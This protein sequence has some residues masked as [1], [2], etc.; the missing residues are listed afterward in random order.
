MVVNKVQHEAVNNLK[1]NTKIRVHDI[2][3][4]HV[5]YLINQ[6]VEPLIIKERLGH[7]DIKIT[8]N[9]YGHLYPN[10]QKQVAE[11]LDMWRSNKQI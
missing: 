5:S 6:G 8:M 11:M 1:N 4:S 9:T 7:K 2:R 10:Q 3:H